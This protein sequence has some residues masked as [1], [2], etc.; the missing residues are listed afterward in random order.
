MNTK[1]L[2]ANSHLA[3]LSQENETAL[4]LAQQAIKL[5][6]KNANAYKAAGNACLSMD[7]NIEALKYFQQAVR[8]DPNNGNRYYD[9]GFACASSEKVVDA[10]KYFAK[11]EELG[12]NPEN[13]AQLYNLLGIICYDIER[14]D[15]ALKNLEK[16]EQIVGLNLDILQRKAVIYAIKNDI[17]KGLEVA[18]Q[19]KLISPSL[20]RGFQIAFNFFVQAK[21][22]NAAEEELNRAKK[23]AI[24][25]M[26]YFMDLIKLELEKYDLDKDKAHLHS[27]LTVVESAL[28]TL[29]PT[30]T[31]VIACY[32]NAAEINLQLEQPDQTIACLN[33]AQNPV[34]AFNNKFEVAIKDYSPLMLTEYD[35]ED[36]FEADQERIAQEYGEYGLEELAESVEADEEGNRDYFTEIEDT[37]QESETAYILEETEKNE[38]SEETVVEISRLYIGAYT[39]KADYDKVVE[40]SKVLQASA[41]ATSV[42]IGKYTEANALKELG[43]PE[44]T[45]K[46][47]EAIRFFRNVMIKD[48]TDL[49][50]V[51]F[52][53]KCCIDIGDY[54]AA[55]QICKLLAKE[56][57]RQVLEQINQ[58]KLGGD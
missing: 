5:D 10:V 26:D 52:R 44:A 25:T 37:P 24:P 13:K 49:A 54:D 6:S 20:Y 33:A 55:L 41:D 3:F 1:D 7:K 53:I 14:Y 18:N 57:Q 21:R 51:N 31:E 40:Y 47:A 48:P 19:V 16:A 58:A 35:V 30:M 43:S 50:A 46:Y 8:C 36:L 9:L 39:L 27:A 12:C 56:M 45:Q 15:D 42:Y 11:A 28:Q 32:I 22:L 17:R 29:R 34:G 23:F 2:I 38:H 4:S